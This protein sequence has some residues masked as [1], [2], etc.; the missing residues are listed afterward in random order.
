MPLEDRLGKHRLTLVT[1]SC[2]PFRK[3][4]NKTV[5]LTNLLTRYLTRVAFNCF[6]ITERN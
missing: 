3:P 4:R 5:P 6:V 1:N 2:E